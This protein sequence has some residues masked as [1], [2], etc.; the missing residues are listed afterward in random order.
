MYFSIS[1][2]AN[3]IQPMREFVSEV[4]VLLVVGVALQAEAAGTIGVGLLMRATAVMVSGWAVVDSPTSATGGRTSGSVVGSVAVVVSMAAATGIVAGIAW[5]STSGVFSLLSA[6]TRCWR[7][8]VRPLADL[9]CGFGAWVVVIVSL[10]VSGTSSKAANAL[11][12]GMGS[13]VLISGISVIIT[14]V[15]TAALS[16]V[17]SR[18][19]LVTGLGAPGGVTVS[20]VPEPLTLLA[21][22]VFVLTLESKVAGFRGA[23][24]RC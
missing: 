19:I 4:V 1:C 10:S 15:L 11:L 23:G 3:S 9:R 7:W 14:P 13:A 20:I 8:D 16:D 12:V 22:V 2:K 5:L 21:K 17:L 24:A 6:C 18:V